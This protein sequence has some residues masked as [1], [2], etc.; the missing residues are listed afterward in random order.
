MG[1]I[2]GGLVATGTGGARFAVNAAGEATMSLRAGSTSLEVSEHAALRLTQRG[3][4]IDE[5]EAT[6]AQD[7]FQYLHQNVWKTGYY[8]ST[9][10]I[11]LGSVS[12]KVTTVI[13]DASLK[14]IN[15]LKAAKP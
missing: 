15:N 11:F 6:L 1:A 2:S 8:D 7:S 13:K 12:G 3:I 4:S 9:T 5:A 14:Y 10:R